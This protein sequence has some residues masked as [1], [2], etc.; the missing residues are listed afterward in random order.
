MF[1]LEQGDPK[2]T[3]L[4]ITGSR[5]QQRERGR[6]ERLQMEALLKTSVMCRHQRRKQ[7]QE[8]AS[9]HKPLLHS[10]FQRCFFFLPLF[11]FM[12]PLCVF[13]PARRLSTLFEDVKTYMVRYLVKFEKGKTSQHL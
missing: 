12:S 1:E 7:T 13:L 10:D 3:H 9:G 5:G 8:V 2:L 6:E 11:L 4:R